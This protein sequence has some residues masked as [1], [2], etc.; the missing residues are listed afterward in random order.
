MCNLFKINYKFY[1]NKLG[2]EGILFS[3][4]L[5]MK[6]LKGPFKIELEMRLMQVVI[7]FFIVSQIFQML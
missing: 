3:D 2:F 5:C 4:D 1:K 6:A 7:L